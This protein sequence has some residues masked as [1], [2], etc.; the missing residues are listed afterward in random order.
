[1]FVLLLLLIYG[2]LVLLAYLF[3]NWLLYLPARATMEEIELRAKLSGLQLWPQNDRH[4]LGFVAVNLP[5][6]IRGTV[7]VFHGNAGAALDRTYYVQSLGKR[8]FRVILAEYPG[9]GGHT[10]RPAEATLVSEGRETVRLA[11]EQFDGPIYVWGES[12]GCGVASA[13]AADPKLRIDGVILLTPWDNLPRTAQAHYWFLP[14][15]WLVRDRFDNIRN[16]QQ[17]RGP[18]AVLMAEQDRV[19]P[20]RLTQRLYLRIAS[21]KRLWIF[22]RA[23]HNSWPTSPALV[24]WSEVMDFVA[25]GSGG[26]PSVQ[27]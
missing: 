20:N 17:F 22:P 4:Y 15:R 19:I 8:G 9:Y 5:S 16:L 26:P 6:P 18:V 7:I 25:E 14:A 2:A 21:A 24:W 11:F 3:Q 12:L 27:L 13:M 10:G 23:G 1:M